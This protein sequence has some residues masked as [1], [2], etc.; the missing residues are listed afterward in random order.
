MKP[1]FAYFGGKT[2]LAER[3][4]TLLPAHKH[5]VEPYCGSLAVLL[6]KQPAKME[7]VNDLDHELITWWRILRDRPDDL[8]RV[9]ALTPHSRTEYVAAR[10]RRLDDEL[11]VARRVWV[12]LSQGRGLT[13]RPGK[14]GWKHYVFPFGSSLGMPGY[15]EAYVDRIAAA[16][17]RLSMVSL[18]CLPAL[19]LIRKYGKEPDVLLYVDPPYLGTT[20]DH[21]NNYRHEMKSEADHRALAEVLLE[22]RAAVVLSGYASD[23]YDRDLY[24]G[25]DRHTLSAFTGNS[26][27]DRSRTEV[28][29]SNRP[30]GTQS[31]LFDLAT[32]PAHL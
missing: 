22:A 14:T 10:H 17:D 27:G 29:W 6:A 30:L 4:V 13:L 23:L 21:R 3:I 20:R 32:A 28:L 31:A 2:N 25:W 8:A 18:E 24:A 26:S 5:Y 7:T 15:L 11:E 19:D 12:M 9:C 1:P 16:A